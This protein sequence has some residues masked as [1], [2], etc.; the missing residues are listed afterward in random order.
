MWTI[1]WFIYFRNYHMSSYEFSHRLLSEAIFDMIL[2]NG[3]N[4]TIIIE[5]PM[6]YLTC[7]LMDLCAIAQHHV[8]NRMVVKC[9]GFGD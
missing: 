5:F 1:Y 6:L 2:S 9:D 3:T 8:H 7:G 4:A